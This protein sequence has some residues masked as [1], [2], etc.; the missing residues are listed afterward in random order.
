MQLDDS[1]IISD[2]KKR[3]ITKK[4]EG[5]YR[6]EGYYKICGWFQNNKSENVWEKEGDFT[7]YVITE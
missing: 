3:A 5:Y 4:F 1:Y 6:F 7:K 2:V